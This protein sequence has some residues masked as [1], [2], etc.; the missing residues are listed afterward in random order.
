MAVNKFVKN[1]VKN[2]AENLA[3][4]LA[5]TT[6]KHMDGLVNKPGEQLCE[7]LFPSKITFCDQKTNKKKNLRNPPRISRSDFA[8]KSDQRDGLQLHP[9]GGVAA[10]ARGPGPQLARTLPRGRLGPAWG[11][12]AQPKPGAQIRGPNHS[13]LKLGHISRFEPNSKSMNISNNHTK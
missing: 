11:P 1:T 7:F 12:W 2:L 6:G 3:K 10:K 5:T 9:G 8:Y 4:H 13:K